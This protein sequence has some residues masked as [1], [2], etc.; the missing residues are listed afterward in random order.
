MIRQAGGGEM[1][2]N[3]YV[4]AAVVL[5]FHQKKFHIKLAPLAILFERIGLY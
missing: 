2:C 3:V 1:I 5:Y 4:R